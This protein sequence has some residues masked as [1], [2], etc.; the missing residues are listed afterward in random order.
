MGAVD[1]E[2]QVSAPYLLVPGEK[3]SDFKMYCMNYLD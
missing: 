3:V 1:T 2:N